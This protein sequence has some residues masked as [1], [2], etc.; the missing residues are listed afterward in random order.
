MEMCVTRGELPSAAKAT[1]QKNREI[2]YVLNRRNDAVLL[3]RRPDHARLMAGMWELPEM[4]APVR[5][6][7]KKQI[8]HSAGNDSL[9]NIL[10][11]RS[12][13]GLRAPLFTVR[14]SI[15]V[16]DYTVRVWRCE[17]GDLTGSEWIPYRR[18]H[19]LPLTGLSRKILQRAGLL[20]RT[21]DR[22]PPAPGLAG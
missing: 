5:Q 21:E 16:T 10:K 17:A 11:S 13:G 4:D 8:P 3:V 15:T 12:N 2:H 19:K 6:A 20:G 1:R 18:L 9:K 7:R 14:H 22:F